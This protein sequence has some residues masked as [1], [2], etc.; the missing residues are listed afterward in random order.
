L[1]ARL[2]ALT[3]ERRQ[4]TDPD[5]A[6][7]AKRLHKHRA[8]LLRFLHMEGLDAT[9]NQAERMLPPTVITR[10]KTLGLPLPNRTALV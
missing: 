3:A 6:R 4:F 7:L 5:H 9:N 10:N 2:D 8:H 1:E